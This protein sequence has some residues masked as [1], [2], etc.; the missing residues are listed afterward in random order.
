M[1]H[2]LKENLIFFSVYVTVVGIIPFWFIIVAGNA[3]KEGRKRIREQQN[4]EREPK[5]LL[6]RK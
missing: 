4:I 2:T 6:D 1:I 3:A 5:R